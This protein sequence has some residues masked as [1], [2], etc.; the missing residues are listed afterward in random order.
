MYRL[1]GTALALVLSFISLA[2]AEDVSGKVK[3]AVERGTLDQP[4]TVP[5]HLKAIVSPSFARD[6]DSGRTGNVEVWWASPTQWR[7]EVQSPQFHQIEIVNGAHDWQKN[8]GDYFPEWLREIAIELLRPV[9]PLK[10]VLQ[11]VKSADVRHMFG[12][13]NIDWITNT[14]TSEVH[15]I[16]RSGVALR[17]HRRIAVCVW[18]GVGSRLQGFS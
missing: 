1:C 9:P 5:F 11:H 10:D 16:K 4:G 6:K 14:G 12:Q 2:S 8:E 18:H 17:E 7:R 3:K 15:N 13:I